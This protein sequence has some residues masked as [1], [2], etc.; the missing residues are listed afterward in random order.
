MTV[1]LVYES[2]PHW[3]PLAWIA[4]CAPG[5]ERVVVRYGPRVECRPGWFCEA[6]W[7]GAFADGDFDR[8]DS[9]FGSGGRARPEGVVFVSSSATVDRLCS[10]EVDGRTLVSNSLACLAAAGSLTFAATETA[11][12][13]V[14]RSTARGI[15]KHQ[16]TLPC[17]NGEIRITIHDN[18]RWDGR[19]LAPVAKPDP[20]RDFTS[21]DGYRGFL[22]ETMAA[23]AA[24]L[25]APERSFAL[26]MISTASSGYDSSAVTV[27]A[28][29]IGVRDVITIE[30]SRYGRDDSGM[31]LIEH[32]G[33]DPVVV[34]RR[35][36]RVRPF[37]D[38][39]LVVGDGYGRDV[40]LAGAE[41]K[42]AGRALFTGYHGDIVWGLGVEGEESGR[43]ISRGVGISGLSLAEY[44]LWIG[45]FHCPVPFL[46]ARDVAQLHALSRSRAMARWR[47]ATDYDRPIPR[48]ILED[49][50]VARAAFGVSKKVAGLLPSYRPDL[51]LLRE[52]DPAAAAD[53]RRW[54]A[55]HAHE[56]WR[57][58]KLPPLWMDAISALF[59][60]ALRAGWSVVGPLVDGSEASRSH[61]IHAWIGRLPPTRVSRHLF[62]WA[63]SHAV[64]RYADPD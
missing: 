45:F 8:S 16:A 51:D 33:L 15:G 13:A 54:F 43:E 25:R 5:S 55:D 23:L 57:R 21:Y 27:L 32:L 31:F 34:E 59:V 52:R 50:G 44:R 17:E 29:E 20:K 42:L 61:R 60:S 14:W 36:E 39:P 6:I 49:A 46:G 62:P 41:E 12:L 48:R 24:N 58:A 7:D 35:P 30:R 64:R 3:P 2:K 63:M 38:V 19:A 56:W 40:F 28:S 26:D 22:R 9:V 10:A 18:L 1:Q 4:E 11:S 37:L 47:L 53:E